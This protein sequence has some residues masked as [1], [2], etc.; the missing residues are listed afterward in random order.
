MESPNQRQHIYNA[1]TSWGES[2]SRFRPT[3]QDDAGGVEHDINAL[4]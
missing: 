4:R 1:L 3:T 2:S